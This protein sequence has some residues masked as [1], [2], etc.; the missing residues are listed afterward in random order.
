MNK[1]LN[2][3]QIVDRQSK[4]L[5]SNPSAVESVFFPQKDFQ[6]SLNINIISVDT[7]HKLEKEF[8]LKYEFVLITKKHNIDFVIQI[9]LILSF[10][11][12]FRI[13]HELYIIL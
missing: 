9:I 7:N 13:F 12:T 6:H 1:A 3:I 10:N 8:S 5:G 4:D 11:N 2:I